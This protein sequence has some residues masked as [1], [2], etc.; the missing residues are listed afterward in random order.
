MRILLAVS[1]CAALAACGNDGKDKGGTD[2]SVN[3]GPD[4]KQFQDAP[5]TQTVQVTVSGQA[6]ERT[7][8]GSSP[9]VGVKIEAFR[10]AANIRPRTVI[11]V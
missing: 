6:T 4:A 1:V 11:P 3:P 10:N 8:Q 5:P 2:A 9:A 7:A